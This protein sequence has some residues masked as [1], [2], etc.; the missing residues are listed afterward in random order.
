MEPNVANRDGF[1]CSVIR[2]HS[3]TLEVN[4]GLYTLPETI[5]IRSIFILK[6]KKKTSYFTCLA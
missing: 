4:M 6:L 3:T 2:K 5:N 1:R